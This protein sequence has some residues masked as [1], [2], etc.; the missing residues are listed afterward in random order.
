VAVMREGDVLPSPGPD[1]VLHMNGL[2]VAVGT[3]EGLDTAA[4]ILRRG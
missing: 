3:D 4:E 2:L 1:V